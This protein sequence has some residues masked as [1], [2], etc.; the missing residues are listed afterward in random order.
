MFASGV[1][2]GAGPNFVLW[3]LYYGLLIVIYQAVGLGSWK[4]TVKW[5]KVTGWMVMFSL[6]V[7]GWLL[8]RAPSLGWVGA[9]LSAPFIRSTSDLTVGLV[10][11]S[12]VGFYALPLLA[13]SAL[14][15]RFVRDSWPQVI[16]HAA[17]L[18]MVLV[19]INRGTAD[20]IYAQF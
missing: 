20:F 10:L 3:G 15:R 8:F 19:F 14:D 11:A 4:P 1:W 9:A 6:I 2:H 16:Y 5:K 17:A 13:K 18:T 7:F 12:T